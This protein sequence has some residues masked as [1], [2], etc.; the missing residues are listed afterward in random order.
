[1]VDGQ[2]A[3]Q[4]LLEVGLDV[5]EAVVQALQ[6]LELVGDAGRQGADGDVADVA[7]QVLDANLL[8]LLGLDDGGRVD[9]RLGGGGAVLTISFG[10]R[11][12]G[13]HHSHP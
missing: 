6:G 4:D 3:V 9:K 10:G 8:G 13:G 7:Q 5:A 1:M 12:R 11:D 2:L